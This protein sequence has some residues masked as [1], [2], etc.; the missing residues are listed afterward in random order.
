MTTAASTARPAQPPSVF[1]YRREDLADHLSSAGLPGYRAT[2]LF[3]WLYQRH[4]LDPAGMTDLP[5]ALRC[6]LGRLVKLSLPT[7]AELHESK[8]GS[9]QKFVLELSDG[10][11]VECVA[12]RTANRMT[13]CVSSQ[14][15]CALKCSFCA[16]GL[17]GL[18]R[19]LSA[20]EIV[21]QVMVMGG[22]HDWSDDRFNIVFMGMGEPLANYRAVMDAIH[23]LHDPRGLNLGA[24]RI[25]VSTSGLVPQI[26][27]LAEEGLPLGLALSLHATTDELRNE[28]VPVN[29]RWP[30]AE[31]L[32]AAREYGER[33]GR[34]VTLEYTLIAGVN[35]RDEDA[36]RL[37]DVA[38]Q[39]PSKI[40]LIPYNPVPGLGLERPSPA[41]VEAFARRLYPRAPAVMI[42]NTLGGEI[43]A[44]C[45]Q[46]GAQTP[47]A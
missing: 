7:V 42:R 33:T 35:D 45:G 36:D 27:A 39:M 37:S 9:T 44:A 43:W 18:K 21:A 26:R 10:A 41:T 29:R 13:L 23:I 20:A 32:P 34:R 12:M 16:T 15:G 30:L 3:T 14:V 6:D 31:L 5:T 19:N 11:R 4:E 47:R 25:T 38:R 8:D 40:N 2:Q 22:H 46:L 17:M 28:L 1:G 24:R